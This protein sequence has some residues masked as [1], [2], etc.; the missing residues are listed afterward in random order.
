MLLCDG[1]LGSSTYLAHQLGR[2]DLG[3]SGNN[4]ALTD[5][6]GLSGHGERI[7]EVVA[8]D[9]VLDEH[10]LDLDTPAGGHLLDN[11]RCRL[12]DLLATL[13]HVL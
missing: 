9:D 8:E 10:G 2:L 4:L 5:S 1:I 6:L 7:L 13:N 11:L 3:A 12:G